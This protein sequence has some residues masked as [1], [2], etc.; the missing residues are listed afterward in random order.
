MQEFYINRT[1]IDLINLIFGISILI[2]NE[3][4]ETKT[5]QEELGCQELTGQRAH[6][7][8]QKY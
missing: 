5:A 2:N 4:L 8:T 3:T 6:Y 1:L 7:S